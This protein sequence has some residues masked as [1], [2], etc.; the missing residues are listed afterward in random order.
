MPPHTDFTISLPVSNL[1]AVM[2]P[3]VQG[4]PSADPVPVAYHTLPV[5][6]HWCDS[7]CIANLTQLACENEFRGVCDIDS[8][9]LTCSM[10]LKWQH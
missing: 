5:I 4:S 2:P 3:R 1:E 9:K 6:P 10:L 7:L 8:E